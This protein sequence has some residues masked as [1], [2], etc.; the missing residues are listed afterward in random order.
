MHSC[1]DG[2]WRRRKGVVRLLS[3]VRLESVS[4]QPTG[5]LKK[6]VNAIKIYVAGKY[7]AVSDREIIDNVN[8]ALDAGL[9][10]ARRGHKPYIPHLSHFLEMRAQETGEGLPYA[11]YLDF[12]R[13]WLDDCDALLLLSHSPGA[14]LELEYAK[15][16]GLIVYYD[17]KDI[18]EG[19]F[20]A[21]YK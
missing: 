10:L 8:A 12:D 19:D 17:E 15:E 13:C 6:E 16:L 1:R 14:D 9:R 21:A 4:P 20:Y 3:D 18:P 11:W 7:S 5:E 2:S